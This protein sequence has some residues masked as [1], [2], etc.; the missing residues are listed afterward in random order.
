VGQIAPY[1]L[2]GEGVA[3]GLDKYGGGLQTAAENNLANF[4]K[5]G[6][7]VMPKEGVYSQGFGKAISSVASPITKPVSALTSG[8]ASL[9]GNLVTSAASYVTGLDKTTIQ[10]IISNPEAFSKIA[11]DNVDRGGLAGEVKTAIDTRLTDL[12]E[13]GKG[14]ENLRQIPSQVDI[15]TTTISDVLKKYNIELVDGKI[16]T[17][18]ESTP[19]SPTD[20]SQ[21]QHFVDTYGNESQLS[22]NAFLNARSALSDLSKYDATKT[23]RLAPIARDLRG[24]YD[25]IGKQTLPGLKELDAV[26]APEV[27]FL[28]K[29]KTDYLNKDGTFKDGAVNKIANSTGVGKE[30]LLNRLENVMPGIT[31][32]VQILKAVE[33]IEKANGIKA[34]Q[35]GK[36]AVKVA[37]GAGGYALGGIPGTIVAEI[38]ANPSIAVPLLRG[39]GYTADKLIPILQTLKNFAGDINNLKTPELLKKSPKLGASIEDV[40]KNQDNIL[41]KTPETIKPIE[42]ATTS[43]NIDK[44][45][46]LKPSK[47]NG[48]KITQDK[49][50]IPGET[51]LA[52]YKNGEARI[53]EATDGEQGVMVIRKDGTYLLNPKTKNGL[54]DNIQ[55]A[56]KEWGNQS[57][58]VKGEIKVKK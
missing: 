51:P 55:E 45:I 7:N 16:K 11:Q 49:G 21:L 35:Y 30:N 39:Y 15:P 4:D 27:T 47:V 38:I 43:P 36:L 8:A 54:F 12:S 22:G 26:Y 28:K 40:S 18:V 3:K 58:K 50:A 20:I 44:S 57:L 33:D 42:S 52:V 9:G 41:P 23:G 5:T 6:I 24:A 34:Y 19:L 14:Y 25:T 2:A 53:V 46:P 32:R 29:I 13:T 37:V 56:Q 10:N 31:K 17:G 48:W 1:L